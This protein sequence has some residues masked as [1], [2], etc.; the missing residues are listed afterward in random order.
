[1]LPTLVRGAF[2]GILG[3]AAMSVVMFVSRRAGLLGKMPP[4][5][6]TEAGLRVLHVHASE[7]S[8]QSAT[9]AGYRHWGSCRLLTA[10]VTI[11]RRP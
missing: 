2:A 9:L 10:I 6:L 4:E 7:R 11:G 3:T 8:G 1:V 5:R